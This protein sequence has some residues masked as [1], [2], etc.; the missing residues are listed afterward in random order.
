MHQICI[1]Q[2]NMIIKICHYQLSFHK[3][4]YTCKL[5]TP[6]E[7]KNN[8]LELF[9]F[10]YKK[11]FHDSYHI[12]N[13]CIINFKSQKQVSCIICSMVN[14]NNHHIKKTNNDL[15]SLTFPIT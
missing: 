14:S 15:K 9:Q 7:L 13:T 3:I 8:T 10:Y 1:A 5:Y 6:H 4:D 12:T 2:T 11:L